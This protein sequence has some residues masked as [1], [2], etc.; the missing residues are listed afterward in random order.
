MSNSIQVG[1]TY[2]FNAFM[3]L[4]MKGL[5]HI[6]YKGEEGVFTVHE[7]TDDGFVF[8]DDITS[9]MTADRC[10]IPAHLVLDCEVV[11][12]K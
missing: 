8:T 12:C 7:V 10:K 2:R 9:P 6:Q 3:Q 11:P 1:T 5:M 4:G